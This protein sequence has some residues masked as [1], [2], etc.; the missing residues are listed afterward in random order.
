MATFSR[1]L[2]LLLWHWLLGLLWRWLLG[3]LL[4][5]RYA[6]PFWEG[7]RHILAIWV[8]N[9]KTRTGG[10]GFLASFKTG[11][12]R[13]VMWGARDHQSESTIGKKA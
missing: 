1:N 2:S 8:A 4:L 12:Y 9:R 10:W 7:L 11:L 13:D 6:L 3:W 5:P